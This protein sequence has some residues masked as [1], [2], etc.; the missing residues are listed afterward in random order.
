MKQFR[1]EWDLD[2]IY[3]VDSALY[4]S[5]NFQQLRQLRWITLVTA[6]LKVVNILVESLGEETFEDIEVP[7]YRIA[8]CCSDYGGV[9]QR[10]LVVESESGRAQ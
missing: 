6:S 7:G 9:R 4:S 3:V 5:D 1:E 2:S 8:S 10:W